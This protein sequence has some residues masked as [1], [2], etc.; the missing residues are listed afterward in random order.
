[1]VSTLWDE[2]EDLSLLPVLSQDCFL[3]LVVY[4][5]NAKYV[6]NLIY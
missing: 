3:S 5:N 4:R 6:G 2:A 1:M